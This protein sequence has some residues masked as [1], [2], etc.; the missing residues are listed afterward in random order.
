[1]ILFA[2]R[3]LNR[4]APK[5]VQ[6]NEIHLPLFVAIDYL[7]GCC[8]P[9]WG[10]NADPNFPLSFKGSAFLCKYRGRYFCVFTEHQ[11]FEH[12]SLRSPVEY[13]I[14]LQQVSK[15]AIRGD[16]LF[17]DQRCELAVM[18][19]PKIMIK[20]NKD[21]KTLFFELSSSWSEPDGTEYFFAFG[22]PSKLTDCRIDASDPENCKAGDCDLYQL[23]VDGWLSPQLNFGLPSLRLNVG[24]VLKYCCQEDLDGFS[25]GPIFSI[26]PENRVVEFRGIATTAGK[27]VIRFTP[28]PWVIHTLQAH[29]ETLVPSE[30]ADPGTTA[31][32]QIA[33]IP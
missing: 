11:I 27:D 22:Y 1:M 13:F 4:F 21:E 29:I 18:A 24:S 5:Y 14:A 20:R 2:P 12:K 7:R 15:M 17:G 10:R 30:G 3:H 25:G 32:R 9:L 6:A 8:T 31:L 23:T 28:A 33:A 26:H 19:I 16:V